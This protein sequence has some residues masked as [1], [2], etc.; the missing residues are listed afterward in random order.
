MTAARE[1]VDRLPATAG[2][3][4]SVARAAPGA[5]WV[6]AAPAEVDLVLDNLL[7]NAARHAR[8]KITVTVLPRATSVW[9]VVDDDGHGIAEEHR[10]RV[11]DRFY[12]V[13]DDRARD[14]RRARGWG[15]RWWRRSCGGG[16]ARW[17]W[18]SP[19]RAAPGSRSGGGAA[20]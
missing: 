20:T 12:R 5:C 16:A 7:R 10:E 17:R 11:F 15:W 2:P 18:A 13:Q 9:L 3:V 6:S 1:A 14:L 19:R 4:V 8:A